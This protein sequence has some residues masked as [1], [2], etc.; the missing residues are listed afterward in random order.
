MGWL[1]VGLWTGLAL[2]VARAAVLVGM[3]RL[4]HGDAWPVVKLRLA[5][6]LPGIALASTALALLA[7]LPLRGERTSRALR[8]VW[9]PLAA[10]LFAALLAGWLHGDA[11]RRVG[12]DTPQGRMASLAIL[13][14][15]AVLAGGVLV[16]RRLDRGGPVRPGAGV[17]LPL[18]LLVLASVA[19]RFLHGGV[20]DTMPVRRVVHEL[21]HDLGEMRV[22]RAHP[23][24]PPRVEVLAPSRSFRDDGADLPSLVLAPGS[25]VTLPLPLDV[26]PVWLVARAGVDVRTLDDG[27][28]GHTLAFEL[29]LDGEPRASSRHDLGEGQAKA[30]SFLGGAE[31][32][33]VGSAAE[34][35][36]R[37]TLLDPTGREVSEPPPVLCGVAELTLERRGTLPRTPSGPESPNVVLVVVDTL[38]AD[39]LSTYGYGR[40]TSPRLDALAR[41][42][43]VFEEAC[44]T[45][46]WTW[47]AT[48]SLFTGMLP[49]EHGVLDRSSAFLTES[50]TTLAEVLQEAG[51][52]TA[53]WTANPLIVPDKNFD[54]GFEVFDHARGTFRP[55]RDFMP[56]ALEWLDAIAGTR[57]FL[58][59][60]LV[61]PHVPH[62]PSATARA[63]LVDRDGLEVDDDA[64]YRR[65]Q[66]LLDGA[67]HADD[68]TIA[69]ERCVPVDEQHAISQAYDACVAT[70]DEWL[71][72]LVDRLEALGIADETV[73]VFTSDHGEELLERG[74]YG[75][76]STLHRELVR[77]PLV[78]AGPGVP[79]GVREPQPVSIRALAPT[80]MRLARVE[81]PELGDAPGLLDT[82]QRERAILFSTLQ[83]WWN[84]RH[85]QPL[86]GL[87]AGDWVLHRAPEGS[88]WGV[89]APSEAGE[90]RL[91]R[92]GEDPDERVDLSAA[93]PELTAEL[94]ALLE[95]RLAELTARRAAPALEAGPRTLELLRGIGYLGE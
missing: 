61:D 47:P 90:H 35:R 44:S 20:A 12:L 25:D 95:A 48:A 55:S 21:L 86:F 94:A 1:A 57:F 8:V 80:I 23:D 65:G 43:T 14:V 19:A 62:R 56:A 83:G 66:E 89:D 68:G 53:A 34:L 85:Q 52:T 33:F 2:T 36:L 15:G 76:G 6:A 3:E 37:A 79:R 30:W 7:T 92:V 4:A 69:S 24:S 45:S 70:S 93:E 27:L 9:T 29:E 77:V 13:G 58:Y 49:E 40:P 81:A 10:L 67:G 11:S 54:Q 17:L 41:E 71:G 46:S 31:G 26:G 63:R 38:R 39:R 82:D 32:L 51:L 60:H 78:L 73:V 50:L 74:L 75:H 91:Y 22:D 28:E 59:L 5:T 87:R 16:A 84:G 18:A 88:A 42:G 64:L 72:A